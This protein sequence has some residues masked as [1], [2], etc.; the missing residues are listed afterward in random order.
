MSHVIE[1][2]AEAETVLVSEGSMSD[3]VMAR[4]YHSAGVGEHI[5]CKRM[6]LEPRKPHSVLRLV[7][8]GSA[9]QGKTGALGYAELGW[10]TEV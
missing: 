10:R 7:I 3:A 4:R 8:E 2:V 1:G 6:T 9:K 5:T